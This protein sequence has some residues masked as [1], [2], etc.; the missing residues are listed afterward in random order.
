MVKVKRKVFVFVNGA[1][2]PEDGVSL[3]VKLPR[4]G[5]DVLELPPAEPMGYRMGKRG[6]VTVPIMRDDRAEPAVVAAPLEVVWENLDFALVGHLI[7]IS[8][9]D[10][11]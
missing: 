2:A 4:S 7:W 8:P 5:A 11:A 10:S 9:F 6:W 1:S 3:S